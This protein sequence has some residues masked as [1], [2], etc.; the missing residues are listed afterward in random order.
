MVSSASC[1]RVAAGGRGR[2]RRALWGTKGE[3]RR[4]TVVSLPCRLL[5]LLL[6]GSSCCSGS[7]APEGVAEGILRRRR[8]CRWLAEALLAGLAEARRLRLSWRLRKALLPGLSEAR[9]T[10]GLAEAGTLGLR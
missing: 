1:K 10:L 2:S 4:G 8:P 5:R 9:L 7:R 3:G 6:G